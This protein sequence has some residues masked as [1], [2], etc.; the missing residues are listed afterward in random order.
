MLASGSVDADFLW[1]GGF[2]D[3]IVLEGPDDRDG[4]A[5][6]K[7]RKE[8]AWRRGSRTGGKFLLRMTI[9]C[10]GYYLHIY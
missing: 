1:G 2:N 7:E 9:L 4:L 5:S 10:K 6:R 8:E 3:P